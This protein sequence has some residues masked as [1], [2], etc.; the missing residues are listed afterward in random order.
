MTPPRPLNT[1]PPSDAA[2]ESAG[3]PTPV[4]RTTS[5]LSDLDTADKAS[6]TPTP[7]PTPN[8]RKAKNAT[9]PSEDTDVA[10]SPEAKPDEKDEP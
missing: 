2:A 1:P 9:E 6:P 3:E 4:R 5:R 7:S 10:D 8:A